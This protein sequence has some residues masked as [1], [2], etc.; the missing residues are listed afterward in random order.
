MNAANPGPVVVHGRLDAGVARAASTM[1]SIPDP[2]GLGLC[3]A[4][5]LRHPDARNQIGVCIA[6]A[7]NRIPAG[8][9]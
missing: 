7:M 2:A 6:P 3:G 9:A 4:A 8:S 5:D 1:S